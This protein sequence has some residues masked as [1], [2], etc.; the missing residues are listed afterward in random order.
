MIDRSS[1]RG[2]VVVGTAGQERHPCT[3]AIT[4]WLSP[5]GD[6]AAGG[7]WCDVVNLGDGL[8]AIIIGDVSGHGEPASALMLEMRRTI[9]LAVRATRNAAQTIAFVNAELY[10][11]D[12]ER[13]VTAIVA[14]LDRPRLTL[15]FANAGHPPP[16]LQLADGHLF[17]SRSPGDLPL[18]I[19]AVHRVAEYVIAVPRDA[20]L[21]FYTDGVTEH[22]RDT[23]AGDVELAQAARDVYHGHETH[24]A[25]R[26][27]ERVFRN[28]RGE[29]DAAVLAVRCAPI[30][31]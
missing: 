31:P 20:L 26:I 15:T 8:S 13:L 17:L 27:A 25:R 5:A 14:I 11:R 21:T 10:R 24:A 7:D 23:I 1:L 28:G 9:R 19:F 29:D 16:H 3:L 22:S 2:D 6:A 18:G 12:G 30:A 4:R